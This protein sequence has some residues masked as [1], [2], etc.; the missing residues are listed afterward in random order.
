MESGLSAECWERIRICTIRQNLLDQRRQLCS[1]TWLETNMALNEWSPEFIKNYLKSRYPDV[2]Y[3]YQKLQKQFYRATNREREIYRLKMVTKERLCDDLIK[4]LE[5]F[6]W[7]KHSIGEC[8]CVNMCRCGDFD[9]EYDC[10]SDC[11]SDCVR[12]RVRR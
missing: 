6:L 3:D 5:E 8:V 4:Y 10:A 9:C 7:L 1:L 12:H 2:W 11:E